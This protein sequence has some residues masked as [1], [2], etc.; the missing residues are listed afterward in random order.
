MSCIDHVGVW[1]TITTVTLRVRYP[2]SHSPVVE[3]I[4]QLWGVAGRPP[5]QCNAIPPAGGGE[6]CC[7]RGRQN[8]VCVCVGSR[9]CVYV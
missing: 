8:L 2:Q 6:I 3:S 7:Q 1:L 4:H 9:V 5:G